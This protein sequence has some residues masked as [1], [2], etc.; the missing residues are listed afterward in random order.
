LRY[1]SGVS[2]NEKTKGEYLMKKTYSLYATGIALILASGI[3]LANPQT[4]VCFES[5]FS[6]APSTALR[7]WMKPG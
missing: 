2:T 5:I 3:L 4:T 7:R 1:G 6:R